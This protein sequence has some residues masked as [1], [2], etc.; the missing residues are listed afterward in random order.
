MADS[1]A[2]VPDGGVQ[3]ARLAGLA[4]YQSGGIVSRQLLKRPSGN[5][6][7]FAFDDGQELT[8]HTSPFDALVHVLEGEV[9]VR[10]SGV[11]HRVRGG[12]MILL[13]AHVPH[14]LKSVTRFKMTLTMIRS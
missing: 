10:V 8:E 4:E 9:E 12:E 5:V 7:L 13:P 1:G 3:A 2:N 6:T 11:A 14:A